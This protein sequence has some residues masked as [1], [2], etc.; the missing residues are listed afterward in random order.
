ML[1]PASRLHLSDLLLELRVDRYRDL[2]L[3]NGLENLRRQ[4]PTG[5][6]PKEQML[7]DIIAVDEHGHLR[8][9][10]KNAL[11]FAPSVPKREVLAVFIQILDHHP[12]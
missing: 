11:Y 12:P 5:G 7:R 2:L 3:M 6:S 1:D 8:D 4:I 9:W 10:L